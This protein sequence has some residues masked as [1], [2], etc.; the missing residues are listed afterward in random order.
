MALLM[1]LALDVVS[2]TEE[3]RL[4]LGG[5]CGGG[6][7]VVSAL[8]S[9]GGGNGGGGVSSMLSQVSLIMLLLSC[10]SCRVSTSP[11]SSKSLRSLLEGIV[12]RLIIEDLFLAGSGGGFICPG[13]EGF[14]VEIGKDWLQGPVSVNIL[15]GLEVDG[16]G[17]GGGVRRPGRI[18]DCGR[19]VAFPA[20]SPS[21]CSSSFVNRLTA[22]SSSCC[23]WSCDGDGLVD[24]EA[25]EAAASSCLSDSTFLRSCS[26][27]KFMV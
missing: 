17:I 10:L 14:D 4:S 20:L 5:S 2:C 15:M 27:I 3:A 16:D 9:R 7:V 6:G 1:W 11:S 13:D 26:T 21:N 8:E 22:W 19:F 18:V 25:P 23:L 24:E 12:G